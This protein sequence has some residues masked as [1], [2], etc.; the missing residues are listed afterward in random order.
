[1]YLFFIVLFIKLNILKAINVRFSHYHD[2][3]GES[4]I[5]NTIQPWNYEK[6]VFNVDH[7]PKKI[8]DTYIKM[9]AAFSNDFDIDCFECISFSQ[10]DYTIIVEKTN[11]CPECQGLWIDLDLPGFDNEQFSLANV[12]S[13][14]ENT[15]F[16][17]QEQ[18]FLFG[19]WYLY[20]N[21]SKEINEHCTLL[22]NIFI[23]SCHIFSDLNFTNNQNYINV[24]FSNCI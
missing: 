20:F 17:N 6:Y 22:P 4:C 11:I 8:N 15:Y 3:N 5:A 9:T 14:K 24:E 21:T 19:D 13:L 18:S 12:C 7:I 16:I 1:M 2:C 10:N 23:E